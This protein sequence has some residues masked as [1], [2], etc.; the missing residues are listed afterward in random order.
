MV[1]NVTASRAYQ[2]P[3][4][5]NNL[6]EDVLRLIAAVSGIDVDVAA[7]LVSMAGKAATGHTH[8]LADISDLVSSLAGKAA[9]DHVH[10][11]NSLSDVDVS[12][13]A[14]G[15]AL[16][17]NGTQWVPANLSTTSIKS[18]RFTEAR[19]PENLAAAALAAAY[20]ALGHVHSIANVTS[21]QTALD[22]LQAAID[23][24]SAT[25]GGKQAGD[26][27]LTA[28]AGL[29]TGANM[30]PYSTGADTFGQ[31]SLTAFAR[32]ILDDAD[33][34]AVR[35]TIGVGSNAIG[36]KT[37]STSSPSGGTDGDVWYR[38]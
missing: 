24:V 31:T 19:L 12:S 30:M 7:L 22:D 33:E 23:A 6:S 9:S 15:M 26:A 16:T 1:A 21:L 4:A 36:N 35:A 37:V 10:A 11:F 28:L 13:A 3:D 18:G 25:A 20:A 14:T 17:H 8:A 38:Y 2:L 27:T 5:V 34:A 32:T 29:A